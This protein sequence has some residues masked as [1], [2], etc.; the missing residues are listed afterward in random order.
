MTTTLRG[1]VNDLTKLVQQAKVN[2]SLAIASGS[3]PSMEQYHRKVG[4]IEGMEEM[5][6]MARDMLGQMESALEND[7]LPEMDPPP[8]RG[9][10]K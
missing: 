8:P 10:E 5:I 4:R 7:G 3:C 9:K 6:K 2:Q 1:F